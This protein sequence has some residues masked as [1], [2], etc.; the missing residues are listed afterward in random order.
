LEGLTAEAHARLDG[1]AVPSPDRRIEF[2]TDMRYR[3][4]A[5]ELTVPLRGQRL[6]LAMLL[7]DFHDM[8]RQRFS[9][10]DESGAVE[11]VSLRA[12]AVGRLAVPAARPSELPSAGEPAGRRKVWL[13]GWRDLPV[14]RRDRIAADAAIAGPA[15]IEEDYTTVL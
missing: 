2:F 9:Y 13:G 11:I 1:D 3:G 15:V 12:T 7:K 8:H 10:A 4:Q 5:F 14:W 6:D